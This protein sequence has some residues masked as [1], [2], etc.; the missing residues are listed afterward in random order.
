MKFSAPKNGAAKITS[1]E[2]GSIVFTLG[3][4][5]IIKEESLVACSWV[6][7]SL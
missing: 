3:T 2:V 5:S 7:C 4:E 6:D 1:R